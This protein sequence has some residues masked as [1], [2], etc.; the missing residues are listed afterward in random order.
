MTAHLICHCYLCVCVKGMPKPPKFLWQKWGKFTA[1]SDFAFACAHRSDHCLSF[2][3]Y[4]DTVKVNYGRPLFKLELQNP[5][6]FYTHFKFIL[7]LL[8]VLIVFT[9]LE[10]AILKLY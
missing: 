9:V 7:K 1:P 2:T 5:W 8:F 6:L 4:M 3:Q 10:P